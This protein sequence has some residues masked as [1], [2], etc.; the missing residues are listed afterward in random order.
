MSREQNLFIFNLV[1]LMK[2]KDIKQNDL[3]EYLSKT[4]TAISYYLNGKAFPP[5]EELNKIAKYFDIT[6]DNMINK[7]L[8][9]KWE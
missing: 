7:K 8:K 3:A 5:I 6:I 4:P 2:F 1:Q 9:I